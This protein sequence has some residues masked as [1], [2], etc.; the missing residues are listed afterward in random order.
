MQRADHLN[1]ERC[2][3]LEQRLHLYAVLADNVG[4]V[5]AGI[6]HPDRVER[7]LVI[8]NVACQCTERAERISREQDLVLLVVG[9]HDLRPVHHRRHDKMQGMLAR[10]Q[11]VAFLDDQRTRGNVRSVELGKHA[12]RLGTAY[13]LRLRIA[14]QHV[15]DHRTVIR[16]HMLNNHV[17][18]RTAVQRVNDV[19][20][21]LTADGLVRRVKQHGFLIQ[22][23]IAVIGYPLGDRE[24]IF[25]A[26][27]AAVAAAN[28]NEIILDLSGTVHRTTPPYKY[29]Y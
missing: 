8:K 10:G 14:A 3:L 18:Q 26:A 20:D 15:V 24:Q 22:Q 7:N 5:T 16:L 17:V 27:Q 12:D 11:L 6:V 21:I 25:K 23:H 19:F 1:I 2:R 29:L 4:V 9:D 13:H 28:I